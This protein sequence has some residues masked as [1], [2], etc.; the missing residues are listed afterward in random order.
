[1]YEKLIYS[2]YGPVSDENGRRRSAD[3]FLSGRIGRVLM[4]LYQ[5]GGGM[6]MIL[7]QMVRGEELMILHLMV[8]KGGAS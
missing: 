1:M 3:D 8:V 2:T 6:L 7:N 4:I 5:I